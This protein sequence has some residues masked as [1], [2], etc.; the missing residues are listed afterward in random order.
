VHCDNE[1]AIATLNVK[2]LTLLAAIAAGLVSPAIAAEPEAADAGCRQFLP[3]D[4][5]LRLGRVIGPGSAALLLDAPGCPGPAASCRSGFS[6]RS[7]GTLLLGMER[8]HYACAFDA[9]SGATGWIPA[10]RVAALPADPTPPLA[11]WIGTWRLYDNEI[12]LRQQGSDIEADGEAYWPAKTVMP[13]NEGT[14]EGS[15]KPA[16][17]RLHFG[18]DRE[19]C[20]VDMA[21]VGLV[22][23]DNRG[24]GGHNV[25]FTGVFTRRG[26]TRW[27]AR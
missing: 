16:G 25:S 10:A 8:R 17:N 24:C 5:A 7:G 23:A 11:A 4:T 27:R 20:I 15:A 26:R 21:L 3:D 9:V 18:D 13:A 2:D 22:V 1:R 12:V 14:F 6:A 19:G